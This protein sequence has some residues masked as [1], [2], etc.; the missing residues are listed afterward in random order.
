MSEE[1]VSSA[2][3]DIFVLNDKRAD[4]RTEL[5]KIQKLYESLDLFG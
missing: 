4:D 2:V 5:E 1:Y 3:T